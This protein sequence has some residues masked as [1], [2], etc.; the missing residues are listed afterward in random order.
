MDLYT[1][2][3]EKVRK[4]SG[5]RSCCLKAVKKALLRLHTCPEHPWPKNRV[6]WVLGAVSPE[7]DALRIQVS[8][9]F[10]IGLMIETSHPQELNCIGIVHGTY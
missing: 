1:A 3:L 9:R 7:F 2:K 8:A 5:S 6:R 10:L 4:V